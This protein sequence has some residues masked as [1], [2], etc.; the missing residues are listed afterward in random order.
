MRP[1]YRIIVGAAV[2]AVVSAGTT[3]GASAAEVAPAAAASGS[4]GTYYPLTPSRLLDTRIGVGAPAGLVGPGGVV[5][6]QV[7]GRGGVPAAHV[8]AVVL[9]VTE[10]D[11]SAAAFITAYPTGSPRPT[12]S[13]LNFGR[14]RTLANAVTSQLSSDGQVDI[15]HSAGSLNLIVDVSGYYVAD[16]TIAPGADFVPVRNPDRLL[17]TRVA[18][19]PVASGAT[20]YIDDIDLPGP[21]ATV[22]AAVVNITAINAPAAGYLTAWDGDPSNRPLTST[23]NFTAGATVPNMAVVPTRPCAANT[24]GIT[25]VPSI[26]IYN[27]SGRPVNLTVDLQGVMA[28]D[29]PIGSGLRF[30]PIAPVRI[31]DTRVGLGFPHAIGPGELG[32]FAVPSSIA[33]PNTGAIA[34]NITA[35][36]GTK[37][38]F[39]VAFPGFDGQPNSSVLNPAADQ[40]VA[41]AVTESLGPIDQPVFSVYNQAGTVNVLVDVFGSYQ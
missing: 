30:H 9:N 3:V 24:C 16:D 14:H 40:T 11:A 26:A 23:L 8:S 20:L 41:N 19:G 36:G 10:T 2:L 31:G 37:S 22:R 5:H 32:G 38:T 29:A 28:D 13:N 35:A 34:I 18:G 15:Y 7:G 17:D 12:T 33:A 25:A 39:L 4:V 21:G 27:G 1:A 6:L